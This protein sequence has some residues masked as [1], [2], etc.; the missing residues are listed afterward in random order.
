MMTIFVN[1]HTQ[2]IPNDATLFHLVSEHL[3]NNTNGIAI[4]VNENVIPKNQWQ[5]YKLNKNDKVLIIKAT[6]GG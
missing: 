3:N 6:Q 5:T 1:N 2:A 4:A